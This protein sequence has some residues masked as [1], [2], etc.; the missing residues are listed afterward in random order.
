MA[1]DFITNALDRLER[2]FTEEALAQWSALVGFCEGEMKFEAIK[3]L[4]AIMPQ[5]VEYVQGL[6]ERAARLEIE[7]DPTSVEEYRDIMGDVW[8]KYVRGA[9]WQ[10]K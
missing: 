3:L 9:T 6:E 7:P 2:E 10:G 1:F 8:P 5:A 4:K